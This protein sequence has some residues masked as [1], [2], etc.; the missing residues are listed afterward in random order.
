MAMLRT[1]VSLLD[2]LDVL[3]PAAQGLAVRH[4]GYG[5]QPAHYAVVGAALI[6]GIG[7]YWA[8]GFC[9]KVLGASRVAASLYLGPLYGG[10][11]AWGLLGEPL[12]WHHLAGAG[13]ILPGIYLASRQPPPTTEP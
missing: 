3:V 10:L 7:A 1:V 8:Y 11:T 9:Q 2:K 13:L 4:V 12:G 5:A 6:P